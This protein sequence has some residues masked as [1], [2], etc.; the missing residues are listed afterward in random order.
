MINANQT[1]LGPDI[2]GPI[3][4]P[5]SRSRSRPARP[6]ASLETNRTPLARLF[7][8]MVRT[9]MGRK[10]FYCHQ[11]GRR[12]VSMNTATRAMNSTATASASM[13]STV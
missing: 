3:S 11:G 1:P 13:A 6:A 12:T 7:A 5:L 10:Y 8:M 4:C 9:G 2:L